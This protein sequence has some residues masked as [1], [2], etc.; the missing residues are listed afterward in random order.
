[1]T[2]GLLGGRLLQTQC[3]KAAVRTT[4]RRSSAGVRQ[5]AAYTQAL[6]QQQQQQQ[7]QQHSRQQC[8]SASADTSS[9]PML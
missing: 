1:M 9:L 8:K 4:Q 3:D 2:A 7:Q 5:L 6:G